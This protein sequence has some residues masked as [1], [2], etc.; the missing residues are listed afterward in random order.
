MDT[1][2][3]K[4]AGKSSDGTSLVVLGI[5]LGFAIGAGIAL[6]YSRGS[7][8]QNRKEL[9]KWAH[10]RLDVVQRKIEGVVKR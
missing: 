6:V 3:T 9:N 5:A 7:G 2:R 1:K 4:K 10:R 8:E